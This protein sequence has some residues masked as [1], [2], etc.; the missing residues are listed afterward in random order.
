MNKQ[1]VYDVIIIGGSYAGLAAA[2]ALGRSLRKVLI[3]DA[4]QPC[5]RQTPHSHNFLTRDGESPANLA[6][7][8]KTQVLTYPSVSFLTD[9]AIAAKQV[10]QGFVVTTA[11]GEKFSSRKLLL[12]TGVKDVFPDIKGFAACWGITVLHC[13]Y[14]HGYEVNHTNLGIIANGDM[15]FEL[16]KLI[17]NWTKDLS[18]F[19]NGPST[20]SKEDTALLQKKNINIISKEI[21][22]LVHIDGVLQHILFTD[23]SKHVL[24]AIFGRGTF[25]QPTGLA[26]DLGFS[27][28][29]QGYIAVNEFQETTVKG[30][31]AAGDCTTMMRSISASVNS[32]NLSGVFMNKDMINEDFVGL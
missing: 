5:N 10:E 27:L 11:K 2:M 26:Q 7:L 19:T 4:G 31:F 25:E 3:I 8:A 18:L 23:G 14:C 20:L 1:N 6:Q 28:N 16:S 29:E 30:V 13:P 32:G 24:K 21:A 17:Y 9:V 15:A 22:E 12:A